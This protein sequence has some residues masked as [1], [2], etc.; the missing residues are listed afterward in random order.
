MEEYEPNVDFK[1]VID[2]PDLVEKTTGEENE[3]AVSTL[4]KVM[5]QNEISYSCQTL[6]IFIVV[7]CKR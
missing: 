2:L 1:P 7:D 4:L 6:S 5:A 3:T